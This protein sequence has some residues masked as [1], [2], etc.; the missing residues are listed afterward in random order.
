[1]NIA[2]ISASTRANSQSINVSNLI[3]RQLQDREVK[4]EVIDLHELRL[5]VFDASGEG[6]WVEQMNEVKKLL[7]NSDGFVFVSPEW[8]GMMAPGLHNFFYY[9]EQELADKPVYLVGVSAGRGGRYPLLNM[10]QMGYKN[11][12]FVVIPESI[13]FD[14]VTENLVEGELRNDHIYKRLSYGL[15]TLLEYAKALT[16]VRKSGVLDYEQ[17][18]NGW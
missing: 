4:V 10:R 3:K 12:H 1:M 9:L 17:F 16:Q 8:G 13:F 2:I 15:N 11:R 14:H 7:E 6:D 5:P 18:N